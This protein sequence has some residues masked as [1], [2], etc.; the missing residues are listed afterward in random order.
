MNF[1]LVWSK[2]VNIALPVLLTYADIVYN[3]S[4]TGLHDPFC[5]NR[6]VTNCPAGI[7][8][9]SREEATCLCPMM[10]V[11]IFRHSPIAWYV[12]DGRM[13]EQRKVRFDLSA[14]H[15]FCSQFA[16][17][18]ANFGFILQRSAVDSENAFEALEPRFERD[19][20]IWII[21]KFRH[22]RCQCVKGR[23]LMRGRKGKSIFKRLQQGMELLLL[24]VQLLLLLS[25]NGS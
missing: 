10:T 4:A 8:G 25:Q 9:V 5:P 2:L 24:L 21:S 3:V 22:G 19:T 1:L 15:Q 12:I 7:D 14:E 23:L 18:K 11:E 17:Q 6:F 20:V 13:V 16:Q